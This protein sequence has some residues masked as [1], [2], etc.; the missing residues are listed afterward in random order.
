MKEKSTKDIIIEILSE[1]WPLSAKIV[2][3][4]MKKSYSKSITYQACYKVM[5]SMLKNEMIIKKD[6]K[7]NLN[8]S[9]I[10]KSKDFFDLLDKSYKDNKLEK[11]PYSKAHTK[12]YTRY[13]FNNLVGFSNFLANYLLQFPNPKNKPL[14][15]RWEGIYTIFG[16]PK[17]HVT[18]AKKIIDKF[19]GYV[20][21]K[22]KTVYD[23]I[24]G[25]AY[26]TFTKN[27]RVKFGF[28]NSD[29]CDYFIIGD[30]IARLYFSPNFKK[31]IIEL[32]SVPG[33]IFK[34]NTSELL[35]LINKEF[36]TPHKIIIEK[37]P[38]I[39]EQ[40]RKNILKEFKK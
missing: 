7:Y 39:A 28:P 3:N 40:M 29:D 8:E 17:E 35:N 11:V 24:M 30:Y 33:S 27:L 4:R 25:R 21:C 36:D 32:K 16:I 37:D 31:K 6:N 18:T 19:G 12:D 15:F 38:K 1:E 34:Y 2:W 26:S 22:D 23:K 20:L 13:D 14:T 9:W 5:Q 10:K